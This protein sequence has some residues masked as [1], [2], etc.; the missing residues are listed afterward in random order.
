[1]VN[2]EDV[3]RELRRVVNPPDEIDLAYIRRM[4]D[5]VLENPAIRQYIMECGEGLVEMAKEATEEPDERLRL[6]DLAMRK[7]ALMIG[8][9]YGR[10]Q[11]KDIDSLNP[12]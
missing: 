7:I 8:M 11:Q 6:Y 1:M 4:V 2:G 10:E 3:V 12:K 9:A 5:P